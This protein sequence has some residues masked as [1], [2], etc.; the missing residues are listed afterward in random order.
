M[1]HALD[2]GY[3]LFAVRTGALFAAILA[4]L[5]LSL[6]VVGLY[7]M[8]SYMTSERTYEIGVRVA[9]GAD[10]K[11]IIMMVIREG[12]RLTVR[13]T[14]V[15]LIGAFVLARALARLLFGVATADPWS[16]ALASVC[17]LIVIVVA[18]SVPA[19][20]ATRVD[21]AVALRSEWRLQNNTFVE[22]GFAKVFDSMVT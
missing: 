22:S 7:G 13:G 5:G 17:V 21:P 18:T 14:V 1:K 11:T 12:A 2:S 8:V 15:G 9:L 16:F 4:L 6:A 3:G 10:P 20:R 19:Y